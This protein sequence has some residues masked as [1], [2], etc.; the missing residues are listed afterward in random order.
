MK[1]INN[2]NFAKGVAY[3]IISAIVFG[4]TPILAK[5]TYNGGSNEVTL[6]FLR[7]LFSIPFLYIGIIKCKESLRITKMELLHLAV[8]SILGISLTTTM[9]YASYNY[10]SVGMATTIHFIYPMMVYSICVIF[11][12][13]KIIL[14]KVLAIIFSM[15]G[16]IMLIDNLMA[17]SIIGVV[18]AAFS[19]VTYGLFMIYLDKSGLKNMNPFKSTIYINLFNVLWLFLWGTFTD[20]LTFSLTPLTFELTIIIAFLTSILGNALLQLGVKYCGAS[21]ASILCTF[22]PITS[23]ILGI[24]F[25]N[26]SLTILKIIGCCF[27]LL[28]VVLLSNKQK[29][30]PKQFLRFPKL[31]RRIT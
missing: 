17:G 21:T 8:L 9:L 2:T 4:F 23:V 18:L 20:K 14:K 31:S 5:I 12:K 15:V 28:A 13:E 16:I 27:I 3:T 19:G 7:S 10:I 24:I 29:T 30:T 26:E 11:Y 25:L 22:E 6:T 1:F